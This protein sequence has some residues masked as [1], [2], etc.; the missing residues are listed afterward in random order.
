MELK[1]MNTYIL[2]ICLAYLNTNCFSI[3]CLVY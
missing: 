2:G 3:Y 1:Q